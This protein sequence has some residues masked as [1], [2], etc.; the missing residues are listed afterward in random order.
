MTLGMRGKDGH[1]GVG[2]G[3]KQMVTG[4]KPSILPFPKAKGT[5]EV[6]E[7]SVWRGEGEG[8]I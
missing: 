8:G 1:S 2:N 6:Q 3:M 4:V 7:S 5:A